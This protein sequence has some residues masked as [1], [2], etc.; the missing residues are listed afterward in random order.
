MLLIQCESKPFLKTKNYYFQIGLSL[1]ADLGLIAYGSCYTMS[2]IVLSQ[3][4]QDSETGLTITT[5]EGSWFGREDKL[6]PN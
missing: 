5:E 1:A 6:N 2:S 4:Q 3:L